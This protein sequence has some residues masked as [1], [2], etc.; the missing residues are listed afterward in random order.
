MGEDRA[1]MSRN[2]RRR[3]GLRSVCHLPIVP[4]RSVVIFSMINAEKMRT[5]GT[6]SLS[7]C[8]DAA[9]V[10]TR[11]AAVK[12]VAK[13]LRRIGRAILL[14]ATL[15]NILKGVERGI[16]GGGRKIFVVVELVGIGVR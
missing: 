16:D 14:R 6:L 8:D 3:D 4:T 13:A 11:R 5:S 10:V 1:R 15:E 2:S 12:G 7:A 9:S